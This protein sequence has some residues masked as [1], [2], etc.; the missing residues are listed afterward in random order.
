MIVT[1]LYN[2]SN[3]LGCLKTLC[4]ENRSKPTISPSIL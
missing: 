4:T 3:Y 2:N 1:L